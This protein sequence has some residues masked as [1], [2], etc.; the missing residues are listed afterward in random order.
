MTTSSKH[1]VQRPFST[2][3]AFQ[4]KCFLKLG[5]TWN[6]RGQPDASK[7]SRK[8]YFGTAKFS[9]HYLPNMISML[10]LTSNLQFVQMKIKATLLIKKDNIK[11]SFQTS[12]SISK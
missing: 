3:K 2:K 8:T 1:L 4:Q 11:V 9:K 7:T 6:E 12:F 10:S 5:E